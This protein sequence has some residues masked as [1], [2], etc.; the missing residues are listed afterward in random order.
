MAGLG[1]QAPSQAALSSCDSGTQ[2][3]AK[4]GFPGAQGEEQT[5]G[6]KVLQ[7]KP[8]AALVRAGLE[9]A[10]PRVLTPTTDTGK[11]LGDK[12]Q[13]PKCVAR[14]FHCARVA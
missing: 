5:C 12:R 10:F 3:L 14:A 1:K 4:Q 6:H 11:T 13:G 7:V 2:D 9:Q 8:A